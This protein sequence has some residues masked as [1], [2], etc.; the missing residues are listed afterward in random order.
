MK[1]AWLRLTMGL[2]VCAVTAMSACDS[3]P[4][5]GKSSGGSTPAANPPKQATRIAVIPKGTTHVFWKGV[6]RGAKKAGDELGVEIIWKGPPKEDD[7]AQ[8]V[9]LV[10]QFVGDKVSAIVLA[11][12][13][14]KLL[15]GPVKRATEMGIPVSIIDSGLEA[16]AGKDFIGYFGTDNKAAGGQGGKHLASLVGK[17]PVVVMRYTAGS[18]STTARED[19]AIE[20]LKAAGVTISSDNQFAEVTPESAKAKALQ[21]ID[22]IREAKGVFTPNESTTYGTLLALRQAGLAGKVAFVG[23]DASKP[24]VEALRA[25]E[26]SALVVQNPE[27]MGRRGVEQA[28]KKLKGEPT[29][30]LI[31]TGAVLVTKENMDNADVKGLLPE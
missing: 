3:K 18:A 11:P 2:A 4:P 15:V 14:S 6:E 24:L 22:T 16:E 25:G 10:D 19:G 13:D 1:N 31:D 28:V 21:M 12:L 23:F 7:R 29:E 20:S 27:M 8:Q 5:A 9:Q 26:I 30:K 17:G